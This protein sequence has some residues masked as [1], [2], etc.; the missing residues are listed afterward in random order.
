MLALG[1]TV[2]LG[3]LVSVL[4]A[5]MKGG[6]A[7]GLAALGTSLAIL[8]I[9]VSFG[10][11][12]LQ[13]DL[14][15]VASSRYSVA[16]SIVQ[17]LVTLGLVSLRPK[18]TSL[19]LGMTV[20]HFAILMMIMRNLDLPGISALSAL[21]RSDIAQHLSY[22]TPLMGWFICAQLLNSSSRLVVGHVA[23]VSAVAIYS[24]SYTLT[25]MFMGFVLAP[26]LT[27]SHPLVMSAAGVGERRRT[28]LLMRR[29]SAYTVLLGA[30]MLASVFALREEL[31]SLLAP[32]YAEGASVVLWVGL[33]FLM[34]RM[35]LIGHKALEIER[36]TALML[37]LAALS[38][39]VSVM[40]ALFFVPGQGYRG[41]ALA[42]LAGYAVYAVSV[43]LVARRTSIGWPLPWGCVLRSCVA[44]LVS[45]GVARALAT[46]L[47]GQAFLLRV[48]AAAVACA[49]VYLGTLHVLGERT[50]W[51]LVEIAISTIRALYSANKGRSRP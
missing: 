7:N 34:W 41:A 40:L 21:T 37:G 44:A 15:S 22:G 33:G 32:D 19:L 2:V 29:A 45:A 25:T 1:A 31:L 38:A 16:L 18:G 42:T 11:T 47:A 9:A 30:G 49:C 36:R 46:F 39:G 6:E 48:T 20:A 35:A 28:E 12:V 17:L 51:A 23:G 24:S 5:I 3:L 26:L 13:A 8:L 14:R 43:Y 50:L 4:A 10:Q 27:A